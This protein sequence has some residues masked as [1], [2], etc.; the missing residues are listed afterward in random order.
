MIEIDWGSMFDDR[1]KKIYKC[2]HLCMQHF[3]ED[4]EKT[5][6][7]KWSAELSFFFSSKLLFAFACVVFS[8]FLLFELNI[9]WMPTLVMF[10]IYIESERNFE[11]PCQV[12][13][14]MTPI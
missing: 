8:S 1:N 12:A 3:I 10:I 2:N 11:L 5:L 6:E 13:Y 9:K 7:W 4:N 14:E